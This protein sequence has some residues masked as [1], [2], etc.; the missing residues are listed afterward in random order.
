[1]ANWTVSDEL[2]ARLRERLGV[3][4]PAAFAER[5]ITDQL[6]TAADPAERAIVDEQIDASEADIAAGRVTDARQA[7][8][9]IADE[10]DLN[11]KR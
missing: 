1:M 3:E 4:D 6:D 11:L 2:D 9:A 8:R 7:M 5:I 10:F